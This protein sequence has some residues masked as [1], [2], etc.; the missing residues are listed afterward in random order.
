MPKTYLEPGTL[1]QCKLN[2]KLTGS[3]ADPL[4]VIA[5]L[6]MSPADMNDIHVFVDSLLQ[7][8][9]ISS[10]IYDT[11]FPLASSIRV[12]VDEFCRRWTYALPA[13]SVFTYLGSSRHLQ[14]NAKKSSFN[15]FVLLDVKST[16]AKIRKQVV[17]GFS[18]S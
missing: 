13:S 1:L 16:L 10:Q 2:A 8:A 9:G 12:F 7:C 15:I 3:R 11:V 6:L 4:Q 14:M 5:P 17:E 18:T